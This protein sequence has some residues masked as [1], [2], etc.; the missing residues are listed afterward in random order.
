MDDVQEHSYRDKTNT[1]SVSHEFRGQGVLYI[2]RLDTVY[3]STD[4]A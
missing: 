4:G 1:F 3:E 2:Y